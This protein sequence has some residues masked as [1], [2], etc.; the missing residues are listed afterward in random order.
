MNRR[1]KKDLPFS[2]CDLQGLDLYADILAGP[3]RR[4]L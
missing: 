4:S 1:T 2:L 3:E